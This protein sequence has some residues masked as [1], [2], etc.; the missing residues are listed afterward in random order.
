MLLYHYTQAL[1]QWQLSSSTRA[2]V[3]GAAH[4]AEEA[5]ELSYSS[6]KLYIELIY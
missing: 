6:P 1:P 3:L 5:T 4:A 2:A